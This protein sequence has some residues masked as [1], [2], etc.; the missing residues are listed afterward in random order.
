MGHL[1]PVAND[2]VMKAISTSQLVVLFVRGI[3]SRDAHVQ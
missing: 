2:Q 3:L 1:D